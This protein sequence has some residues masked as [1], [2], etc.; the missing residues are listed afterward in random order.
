MKKI[1]SYI[2]E[3]IKKDPDFKESYAIIQQ[4]AQIGKIIIEYRN[5][6]GLTQVDLA[7][8]LGVTQQYIS[9]IEDGEFSSLSGIE[10]ILH[11]IGYRLWLNVVRIRE[12]P[13]IQH[14]ATA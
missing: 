12:K 8:E 9:K 14:C 2:N 3:K 1:S 13:A 10:Q 11:H 6:N 5:K 4:K 7:R